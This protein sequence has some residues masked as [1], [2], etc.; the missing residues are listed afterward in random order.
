MP[1]RRQKTSRPAMWSLCSCV[2]KI[3]SRLA[4]LIPEDSRRCAICRALSPASIRI[5]HWLV[6]TKEQLP[7][8]PLPRTVKLNTP[9]IKAYKE[10]EANQDIAQRKKIRGERKNG[11]LGG[12][13][14]PLRSLHPSTHPLFH[15]STFPA[16]HSLVRAFACVWES[17][18]FGFRGPP[19]I[20]S[21]KS[22]PTR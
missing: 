8:L 3:P 14:P 16:F 18:T 6:A 9:P 12:A 22:N 7:P 10:W 13:L 17:G 11:R 5:L 4:G 20:E 15:P 1:N 21:L 2:M 19:L